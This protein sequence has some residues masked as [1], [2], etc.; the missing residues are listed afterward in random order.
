MA[1]RTNGDGARIFG[2]P[3]SYNG[4]Y[5]VTV[6]ARYYTATANGLISINN[7]TSLTLSDGVESMATGNSRTIVGNSTTTTVDASPATSANTWFHLAAVRESASSFKYYVDGALVATNTASVTGRTAADR[8][9]VALLGSGGT[10]N[11]MGVAALKVWNGVAL[12]STQ[13]AQELPYRNPQNSAGS[14]VLVMPFSSAGTWL[15]QRVGAFSVFD[16]TGGTGVTTVTDPSGLLGD[17][18]TAPTSTPAFG[19]YGVRGPI[20]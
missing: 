8:M 4:A 2:S 14:C 19:R 7:G 20:R 5:S 1:I 10:P 18:P 17:D 11:D 3:V 13:V 9:F 12:T 16:T 6:W 15:S